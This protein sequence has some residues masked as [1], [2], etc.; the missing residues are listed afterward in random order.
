MKLVRFLMKLS[1]ETVIVE[2]KNGTVI[3]GVIT[4]VDVAMN[5]HMKNVKMTI[6]HKNPVSMDHLTVRG[7][8]IRYYILP[9]S[10]PLETLLIDEGQKNKPAKD[11]PNRPAV[12]RGR[13]RGRGGPRGRGRGGGR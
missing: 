6:K 2:L 1:G 10:L 3:Q 4:G 12:Q 11:K 7:N 5:T 8:N 13:A 9:D